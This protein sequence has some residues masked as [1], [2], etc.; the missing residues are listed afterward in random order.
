M[1]RRGPQPKPSAL[2]KLLGNPGK[3]VLNDNE[4]IPPDGAIVAPDYLHPA[5]KPYWDQLAPVLAAMRVLT[6]ADVHVLARLVNHYVRYK[7]LH[8]FLMKKGPAGTTYTVKDSKGKVQ[9]VAEF[10]QAWEFRQ[11]QSAI[12]LHERELGLTPASRTRL[13]VEQAIGAAP[14]PQQPGE[15]NMK[16]ANYF[17]GGGPKIRP[18]TPAAS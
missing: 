1:G 15:P 11:L 10:P 14:Q 5:G 6:V 18:A 4:P 9:R 17:D 12:M 13:R 2:K 3:R 16:I 7:E 8:T